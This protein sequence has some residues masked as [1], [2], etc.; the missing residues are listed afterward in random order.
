MFPQRFVTWALADFAIDDADGDDWVL[1]INDSLSSRRR[2]RTVEIDGGPRLA[3]L[4]PAVATSAGVADGDR[5]DDH[6]WAAALLK[7]D[8]RLADPDHLF[9][10]PETRG[11]APDPRVRT[12]TADDAEAFVGF[13][14]GCGEAELDEAFVELDHW[15]VVGV[16]DGGSILAAASAYPLNDS[17][18]ADIGVITS[19]AMRGRG[20]AAAMT[21][22]L[23]R[24]ILDQG[25]I[26]LYR[27]GFDNVASA[28]TA[29]AAGMERF[30]SWAMVA[31]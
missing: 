24:H 14:A 5:L 15:A 21:R 27:C 20:L 8:E 13:R 7:A 31:Q 9:S 17:P 25:L 12:L 28:A 18:V 16:V 3:A 10:Y 4:T 30:G 11:P 23:S 26:P 22:T 6:A 2:V 19:P 29:R 1:H